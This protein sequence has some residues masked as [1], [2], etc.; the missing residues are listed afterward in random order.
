MLKYYVRTSRDRVFDYSKSIDYI[1]LVDN[2]HESVKSFI[3]QLKYISDEDSVL[4]E[5]DCELCANFKDE[6]EKIIYEHKNMVINFFQD[7]SIYFESHIQERFMWNQCTY[8]PKGIS[9][10]IAEKM[11]E[12]IKKDNCASTGYD[13][14][15]FKALQELGMP[16]YVYR[17]CL[18]QHIGF[19]SIIDGRK[20]YKDTIYFKDY[21]DEL[22]IDYSDAY[23]SDNK[24]KLTKLRN[25]HRQNYI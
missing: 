4:L 22:G 5:D 23:S 17:P 2:N 25:K 13:I 11:E 18:V 10:I 14:I 8:Y 1:T 3:E 12:I 24:E 19:R 21:L 7:P 20:I 16:I 15:E 6:I 9:K